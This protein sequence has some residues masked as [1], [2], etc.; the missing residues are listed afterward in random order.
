MDLS[1]TVSEINGDCSRK[2]QHFPT[3]SYLTPAMK[4]F[5]LDAGSGA[6]GQKWEWW[7][8]VPRKNFDDIFSRLDTIHERVRQTDRQTDGRVDRR[9]LDDSKDRAYA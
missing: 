8:T 9:T 7:A 1:R 2:S 4:R 5:P 3:P 6:R